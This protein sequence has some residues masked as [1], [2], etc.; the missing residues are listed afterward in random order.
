MSSLAPA[1]LTPRAAQRIRRISV[2]TVMMLAAGAAVLSFAGLRELA[3]QAGFPPELAWMFPIIVDGLVLAGSLGVISAALAGVRTAYFWFLTL[4]G[5]FISVVGNI[6]SAADDVLSQA[7]HAAPPLIFALS[8]E[9]LLKVYRHAVTHGEPS[10]PAPSNSGAVGTVGGSG[11]AAEPIA[12]RAP[13][14]SQPDTPPRHT[15][16]VTAG[17]DAGTDAA[18]GVLP[19]PAAK[20][21]AA[22]APAPDVTVAAEPSEVREPAVVSKPPAKPQP[23]K[24][25]TAKTPPARKPATAGKGTARERL[26]ELLASNPDVSGAQAARELN[27]DPS[28]ARRI[29]R[30]LRDAR[31]ARDTPSEETPPRATTATSNT[32]EANTQGTTT[33][34]AEDTAPSDNPFR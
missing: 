32:A 14:T 25:Q 26:A 24:P 11:G 20:E 10:P 16:S 30:E 27:I 21:D 2:A 31:D 29:L 7:V 34:I 22:T 17:A 13:L 23:V 15:L 1:G 12:G 6:A 18:T 9:G 28:H 3:L 19:L 8:V 4:L 5:V 33:G